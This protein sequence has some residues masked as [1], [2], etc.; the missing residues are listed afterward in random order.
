MP[1]P[2]RELT[3]GLLVLSCLSWTAPRASCQQNSSPATHTNATRQST[4]FTEISKRAQDALKAGQ[5]EEAAKLSRQ[6]VNLRPLWTEGWG[7]LAASLYNLQR[8]AQARDAYRQTT[9][10]TPKN[11]PSWAFLGLC[12]YELREYRPAFSHLLKSE[13]LGFGTDRDLTAQVKYHLAILWDTAG[14]FEEGL[15]EISWFPEQNL[16]SPEILD[17]I[18]LSLLRRPW[19]PYEIPADKRQMILKAGAAGYAENTRQLDKAKALYQ[20][21]AT[22]NP[23]ERDIHYAYGRFMVRL[24]PDAALKEYEKE[25]EVTPSHVPARIQAAFLCLKAANLAK[26]L[27]Y[28]QEATK[29]EPKNAAAHNLVGRALSD[30]NR[31]ADAISELMTATRLAPRNPTFHLQLARAYQKSGETALA[32]KEMAAFNDL[33]KKRAEA[34]SGKSELPPQ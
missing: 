5:F 15:K 6:G 28:A 29:L 17:A 33:E 19:F 3:V 10:L 9:V 34:Q 25:L 22:E 27:A 16:G 32:T 30:M 23:K 11:G 4:G 13:Q 24:D 2:F 21:L 26:G 7:Y 20:E 12:E 14:Q 1:C 18:G 31:P 8:Y